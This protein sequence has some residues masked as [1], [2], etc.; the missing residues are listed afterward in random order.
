V[1]VPPGELYDPIFMILHGANVWLTD[2]GGVEDGIGSRIV[3]VD[4]GH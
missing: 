4:L 1:L 2:D 3:S